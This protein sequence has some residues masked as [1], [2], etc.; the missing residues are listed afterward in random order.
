MLAI[1][2]ILL[3]FAVAAA[4]TAAALAFWP[5]AQLLLPFVSSPPDEVHCYDSVTTLD[6]AR[7][8][9]EC[10][11][12]SANGRFA[13]VF[14]DGGEVGNTR[15]SRGTVIPGVWD[16]HGHVLGLG[17]AL[18]SVALGGAAGLEDAV[19]R[20]AAY[21]E[22]DPQVGTPG[23]WL[24]GIGWDQAAFGSMPTAKDL[25]VRALDGK[26]IMLSRV[27]GHCIWVSDAV[28]KLLPDPIPDVPGGEVIRQ[29]GQGVF[30]DNAM[31][32]VM[33]HWPLP[34]D[35]KKTKFVKS[36]MQELNKVGLVG[37]HDASVPVATMKLYE[38]LADTDDWTVRLYGMLECNV[39]NTFCP[40]DAKHISREDGRLFIRSVKLFAGT[41]TP[42]ALH[43]H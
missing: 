41:S 15:R 34:D 23:N 18:N 40:D 27:D 21:A 24:R 33:A 1:Q 6:P 10:F 14:R 43:P 35:A 2:R 31:D 42:Q 7:P 16:G 36:A 37:V 9:A 12:V 25:N 3:A 26:Y 39:R 32:L 5:T 8:R 20:I 30:C 13:R 38:K 19:G 4:L 28:L 17:E 11:S 22:T 29:P